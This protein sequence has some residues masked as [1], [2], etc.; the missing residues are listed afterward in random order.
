MGIMIHLFHIISILS[1]STDYI[2]SQIYRKNK[3]S[4]WSGEIFCNSSHHLR[5]G[6]ILAH[7]ML[8]FS[9]D[10]SLFIMYGIFTAFSV[11]F[12]VFFIWIIVPFT[13]VFSFIFIFSRQSI[14]QSKKIP[15]PAFILRLREGLACLMIRQ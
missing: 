10:N 1:V 8:N 11:F 7:F 6:R 9:H 2:I 5:G 12:S 4:F 13:K 15:D 3:C 14:S